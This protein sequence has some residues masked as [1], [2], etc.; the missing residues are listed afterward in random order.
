MGGWAFFASG[1]YL[2]GKAAIIVIQPLQ[3][4]AHGEKNLSSD[5]SRLR[6]HS[7]ELLQELTGG[8]WTDYN[9]HDPGVTILELLCFAITDLSYRTGFPITEILALR[10]G[11]E[12]EWENAFFP[13]REI[14]TTS[15]VTWS[16]FR[17][18]I[19]DEVDDISNVWITAI[20]SDYSS[21][22]VKGVYNIYV[23]PNEEIADQLL[24][25]TAGVIREGNPEPATKASGIALDLKEKIKKV[26]ASRRN[27]CEDSL[28]EMMVMQ[29]MK[30]QV[31]AEVE[32]HERRLPEQVLA[33]IYDKVSGHFNTPVRIYHEEELLQKGWTRESL[34]TGVLL[35][36]GWIPDSE[37]KDPLQQLDPADLIEIISRVEGV[38]LVKNLSIRAGSQSTDK[39]PISL[40]AF[41][42][43]VLDKTSEGSHIKLYKNRYELTIRDTVLQDLLQASREKKIRQQRMTFSETPSMP[44]PALSPDDPPGSPP[45]LFSSGEIEQYYSIQDHFPLIYGIGREGLP[46]TDA[47]RQAKARQL[48]GYLLLF[49]QIMANYLSQ[50]AHLSEFFSIREQGEHARSYYSQPLYNV[51]GVKDLLKDDYE[52]VLREAIE[53]EAVYQQRKNA[54]YD[55]LLARHNEV[56]DEYPVTFY[57]RLYGGGKEGEKFDTLLKWKAAILQNM[58][59]L[60]RDR[61]RAFDYS[62]AA[63]D[64]GVVAGLEKRM[65]LL[66]YIPLREKRSLTSVFDQNNLSLGGPRVTTGSFRRDAA[67]P[68]EDAV[69]QGSGQAG[70]GD[71]PT[72]V[73]SQQTEAEGRQASARD[74]QA[75]AE[76]RRA[77]AGGRQTGAEGGQTDAAGRQTSAEGRQAAPGAITLENQT[78]SLFRYGID[79]ANYRIMPQVHDEGKVQVLYKE[80]AEVE[81][82]VIARGQSR[83][84]AVALIDKMTCSL[85]Q[86]SL[87]SEGFH[88]VEHVLLRPSLTGASFGWGLYAR[89]KDRVARN[90]SWET[91]MDREHSIQEILNEAASDKLQATSRG[92]GA[93]TASDKRQTG[94]EGAN[95]KRQAASKGAQTASSGAEAANW[96]DRLAA[97]CHFEQDP[98]KVRQVLRLYQPGGKQFFPRWEFYTRRWGH[99]ILREDFFNFRMTVALPAWPA[100]FQSKNFRMFT[101]ELFQR[102]GPAHLRIHFLWLGISEMKKFEQ[103]YF[104]WR[105]L[106]SSRCGNL[107]S[108]EQTEQLIDLIHSPSFRVV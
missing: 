68:R 88:L 16:D 108:C 91:F 34:Y 56:L 51:P 60:S 33:D 19:L 89:E 83:E 61:A 32:V 76:S 96:E 46:L 37:L 75:E 38:L 54:V 82:K 58:P 15:A 72:D 85:K 23:Q 10:Q 52:Q 48:K 24:Q 77:D 21:D 106:F 44:V 27:I 12:R 63:G 62:V 102:H 103:I 53:S 74:R 6:Q 4:D 84:A 50:L 57:D 81:W 95:D 107:D 18:V 70:A 97:L 31:L 22:H 17:K 47:S 25:E 11:K 69:R 78:I 100:R 86:I 80:P 93:D 20:S 90:R 71:R 87:E 101:E 73:E 104:N 28:R 105:D 30:V 64:A 36:K 67:R 49:E 59:E 55:H 5:F 43:P 45:L 40:P 29:P 14:L 39:T 9:L 92:A 1:Y 98:E 94:R 66:L 8:T 2:P 65:L 26:Y 13:A 99:S 42:F 35:K 7:I 41:C 79:P 3:I